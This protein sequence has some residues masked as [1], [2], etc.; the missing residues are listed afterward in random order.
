[1]EIVYK[2]ESVTLPAKITAKMLRKIWRRYL[3]TKAII[4]DVIIEARSGSTAIRVF[5]TRNNKQ[6]MRTHCFD[7]TTGKLFSVLEERSSSPMIKN[8]HGG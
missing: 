2:E 6:W 8:M 4:T 7:S 3:F 1:M 5:Y